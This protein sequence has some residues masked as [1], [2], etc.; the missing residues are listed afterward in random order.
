MQCG[1]SAQKVES[2]KAL[3]KLSVKFILHATGNIAA[4]FL[5]DPVMISYMPLYYL[6]FPF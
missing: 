2:S 5:Y 4:K 1:G 6:F 3:P